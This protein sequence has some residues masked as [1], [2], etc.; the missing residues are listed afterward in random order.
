M[1]QVM[2]SRIDVLLG[3]DYQIGHAYLLGVDSLQDLESVFRRQILPLLQEYFFE[4]WENIALVLND[5]NKADEHRF[6][7]RLDTDLEKLF[8][9]AQL[10][11]TN[12]LWEWQPE[13]FADPAAYV[14][15]YKLD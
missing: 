7:M 1:L 4:D 15:I 6:L 9:R 8:G 12:A 3:R 2:N 11:R 10:R 5:V 13:A 14:G